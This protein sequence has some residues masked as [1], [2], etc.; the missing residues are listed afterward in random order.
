MDLSGILMICGAVIMFLLWVAQLYFLFRLLK[1]L[2]E[3]FPE[4]WQ[5]LGKP[6]LVMNNS[7]ANTRALHRFLWRREYLS[8][9]S[10]PFADLCGKVRSFFI[11]ALIAASIWVCG[12][13]LYIATHQIQH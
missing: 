10:V 12:G 11:F 7:I 5:E 1:G 6:T 4:K 13:A 2:R 9:N 3:E 8:L